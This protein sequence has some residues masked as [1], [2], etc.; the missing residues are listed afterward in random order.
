M[1]V[2]EF[3]EVTLGS[4]N[5]K[6]YEDLGYEI[7]RTK[8]KQG[9]MTTPRGTTLLV[10]IEDVPPKSSAR[11]Y[12][13]CD[14]CG[15]P[16]NRRFADHTF[17]MSK[18]I[19]DNKDACENCRQSKQEEIF[20]DK[21]GVENPFMIEDVKDKIKVSNNDKYGCDNPMFSDDIKERLR[22]SCI[23]KYGV[24]NPSKSEE[25]KQKIVD[26]MQERFGV[27]NIMELEKYR[28]KIADTLSKNNSV[29]TS[30]QQIYLHQLLG[31][32]L[33]YAKDTPILDI[34]FPEEKIYLE[35]NG[36]GHDLCVKLG[37]MSENDFRNKELRRYHYL[38]DK[39]WKAIFIDSDNDLLP[40]DQVLIDIFNKGL[41][42]L[43]NDGF[44]IKFKI[45]KGKVVANKYS[46]DIDFGRLRKIKDKDLKVVS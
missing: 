11:L 40:E 32:N 19:K 41:K 28:L 30:K 13:K 17:I 34:A 15:E 1:L 4:K 3:V 45:N 20:L 8:N 7:P 43:I 39:G 35:Y 24:D 18:D 10:K 27:D 29:S 44:W 37:S 38:K 9:K 2:S 12:L 21:Y 42:Y 46:E 33:N 26:T 23:E 6:Y 22:N 31:G 5:I 16:F 25:V 36:G 14:Y